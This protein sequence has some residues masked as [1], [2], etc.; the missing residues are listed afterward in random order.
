MKPLQSPLV[1]YD[2]I[3]TMEK[4]GTF[5]VHI[6]ALKNLDQ[7][8]DE[9]CKVYQPENKEEEELLLNLCP[10]FGVVWPSARALAIFMSERK[11][12]FNKKKGIEVG[13]G[14]G[15]PSILASKVGAEIQASDFHPDVAAWV[16]QNAELNQARIEYI[17]WDWTELDS[18]PQGIKLGNYDFVLASDVLY[19][20]RHPEELA[21]ALARL[22]NP[23]GSIYLSDPGRSYLNRA[24]GELEKLG[25]HRIDFTYEVEESSPRAEIRL[26]KK[27]KIQVF[28][29]IQP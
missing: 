17:R 3:A 18:I 22:V 15:L 25:F 19:E 27:R 9:I 2:T 21:K 12:Q 8:L 11:S 28:E 4:I 5:P 16:H 14:L 13:C 6:N 7:S 20:S 29:F 24:L 1:S 23:K 10:Y 26:E